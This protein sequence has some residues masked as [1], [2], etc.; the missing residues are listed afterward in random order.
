MALLQ[1]VREQIG[2]GLLSE[3]DKMDRWR[4]CRMWAAD[5]AGFNT[6]DT[7]E[8]MFRPMKAARGCRGG[9][10]RVLCSVWFSLRGFFRVTPAQ[11]K[12]R[13]RLGGWFAE[14]RANLSVS[15]RVSPGVGC[16]RGRGP[17]RFKD[18]SAD[19]GTPGNK[20]RCGI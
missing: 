12:A 8:V 13:F 20:T 19:D 9:L 16:G 5:A 7:A 11:E 4:G 14:E 3:S 18:H 1:R 6:P 2:G 17:R 15:V 10:L